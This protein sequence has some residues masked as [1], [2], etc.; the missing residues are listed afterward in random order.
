MDRKMAGVGAVDDDLSL[1]AHDVA[2]SIMV[3]KGI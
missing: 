3:E 1:F 2:F